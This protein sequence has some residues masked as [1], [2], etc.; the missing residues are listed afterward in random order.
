MNRF[1]FRRFLWMVVVLFAVS[2]ITF[3]L[4]HAVPGGPFSAEKALPPET[5][6]QL[7]A[8][9][10][11]DAPITIQYLEYMRDIFV[12]V[13]M[14]GTQQ[15]SLEHDYLI[16]L[17]LP[18]GDNVVL[19]WANF[20]PSIKSTSRTVNDIFRDNFPLSFQ[21]GI[22]SLIVSVA[23]G[24]PLGIASALR[25]NTIYD[26]VGMGVAIFGASVPVIIIAPLMQYIFGVQL[27]WLPLTGWGTAKQAILPALTLGIGSSAVIAR[28][29]RASILQTMNEDFIRTARAKGLRER[30][31]IAVHILKNSMI[32]VVTIFGPMLAYLV[33]GTFVVET[34][35]A[36]PGMGRFFV[37]SITGRD[38]PVIMGTVLF[39]AIFL[40][41]ANTVVDIVYVW[42]DPRIHYA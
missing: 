25:R 33:T 3:G 34:I 26:Y 24:L 35:F 13:V 23:I 41:T 27:K 8:K 40:V 22:L 28:L 38:Y 17:R 39:F 20:G 36:I 4:M 19:H 32:P 21:L 37:T 9:Y 29:A 7:N 14:S 11:L 16:N 5:M 42:L 6:R 31:I 1:I 2:V 18:F 30:R 10:H 12:P 15:K